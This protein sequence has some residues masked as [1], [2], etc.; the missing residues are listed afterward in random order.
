M[1]ELYTHIRKSLFEGPGC[2]CALQPE[3]VIDSLPVH[4]KL[5]HNRPMRF[6]KL[7]LYN[8]NIIL[9]TVDIEHEY[10]EDDYNLLKC[11]HI[12]H[13]L[14]DIDATVLLLIVELKNLINLLRF[15]AYQGRFVKLGS[16]NYALLNAEISDLFKDIP[17]VV[18]NNVFDAGPCCV[19]LE[20]T[21][22]T[23][24]CNHH[25]CFTCVSQL[26]PSLIESED[27][28]MEPE[29]EIRCPVCR[30]ELLF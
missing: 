26:H 30:H 3:L 6:I 10:I 11:D 23:S 19:C 20:D 16:P 17:T 15:D 24:S 14:P 18:I 27:E 22:T 8:Y 12:V 7:V 2:I 21:I 28:Q 4:I 13:V 9:D 5:V 29:F 1:S 25:I